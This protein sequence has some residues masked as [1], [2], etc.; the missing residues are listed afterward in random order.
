[1]G[2]SPASLASGGT[3]LGLPNVWNIEPSPIAIEAIAIFEFQDDAY[4]PILTAVE[5]TND[6]AGRA[7]A[8]LPSANGH[9][10]EGGSSSPPETGCYSTDEN[11]PWGLS[12]ALS[13]SAANRS[14]AHKRRRCFGGDHTMSAFLASDLEGRSLEEWDRVDA[15][16]WSSYYLLFRLDPERDR[17]LAL[18]WLLFNKLAS[19]LREDGHPVE[20]PPFPPLPYPRRMWAGGEIAWSRPL[21]PRLDLRRTTVVSRAEAKT[22]ETGSFLLTS[23]RRTI[24]D[25]V[26]GET[27]IDE[28]QDIVFLPATSRPGSGQGREPG[29]EAEWDVALSSSSVDLFRYSALTLNGHRIHYDEPYTR[30]IEGYPKLVVH[31]PRLASQLMHAAARQRPNAIPARFTYRAVKPVFCEEPYRLIGRRGAPSTEDLAIVGDDGRVRM[32]ATM[33]FAEVDPSKEASV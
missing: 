6:G 15:H 33:T 13:R 2:L 26:G 29:F 1:M 10:L 22:G 11:S 18:H 16:R 14:S 12:F 9:R 28:R 3:R 20:M 8:H 23:L 19:E 32:T 24:Q 17:P 31:G 21:A 30:E 27:L 7:A 4:G 5:E 25:E